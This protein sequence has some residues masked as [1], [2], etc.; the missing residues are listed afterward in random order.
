MVTL[1]QVFLPKL[2]IHLCP[3]HSACPAQL[4]LL[5]LTLIFGKEDKVPHCAVFSILLLLIPQIKVNLPINTLSFHEIYVFK[6][7]SSLHKF[8]YR[9]IMEWLCW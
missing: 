3:M 5:D 6:H 9:V 7:G 4:I 2:N 1:L 8:Q